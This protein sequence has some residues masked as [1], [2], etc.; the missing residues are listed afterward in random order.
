MQIPYKN[1]GK[2][3]LFLKKQVFWLKIVNFD[4]L[5]PP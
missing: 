5:K 2:T 3:L 1:L 4:E